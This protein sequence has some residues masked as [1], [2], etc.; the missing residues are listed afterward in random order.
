[1]RVSFRPMLVPTLWFLPAFAILISLGV[2][3]IE[4]LHWK[5]DLLARIHYGLS[6][7]PQSLA[8]VLPASDPAHVDAADYRRVIARGHFDNAQQIRFFTTGEHGL[9]VYHIV[10]PFRLDDGAA[11]IVDRGFVPAAPGGRELRTPAQ[12]S[13]ERSIVGVLRK[14]SAPNWFT[15]PADK[16]TRVVHTRDPAALAA[17]FGWK[18]VLP[19]F[20][21][22]DAT[23]NP[24]GWPKGGQTIV[25]LPNNHMQYALTWFALALGLLIVFLAYHRSRGR[26]VLRL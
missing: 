7:P 15:P 26:L 25:D 5:L 20:L 18:N 4:R 24:G 14:P 21:E 3:Q 17:A 13:G 6:A 22:A 12:L 8:A 19:V 9:P 23:P 1:M 16:A 11:L 2:W 10:T